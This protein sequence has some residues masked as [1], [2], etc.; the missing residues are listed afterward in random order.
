VLLEHPFQSQDGHNLP[1]VALGE[2]GRGRS[3]AI[4]TDASW[5]WSFGAAGAGNSSHLYDKFWNNAIRWLVRDPDLTPVKV[6]SERPAIEPGEAI[7][8]VV[9]ARTPD[10][11]PAAGA[12]VE[13]ELVQA[14]E[15]RPVARQKAV[16]GPDGTARMELVPPKPGPYKVIA[17]ASRNGVE[18][19]QGEDAVAVRA[20]GPEL[21]DAAPRP[22]LLK[23]IAQA[24][25][26]SFLE[27][28]TSLPQLPLIDPET[29]EVGR[30]KDLPIWDRWWLLAI[31]AAAIASEWMLRRRWGYV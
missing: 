4:C 7:A 28:P 19:G 10:W 22:D 6:S 9:T 1:V 11:G 26:G 8:A 15:N 23:A 18:L 16:A 31:L 2:Y 12:E 21:S 29:V 25:G 20:A 14:D 27:A 5:M 3:M 30:R 24:T 13:L 17:K